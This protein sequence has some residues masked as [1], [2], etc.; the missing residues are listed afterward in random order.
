MNFDTYGA[1]DNRNRA[2]GLLSVVLL[3]I[4]LVWGLM[5]GLARKAVE[6]L[7]DPIETKIIEEVHAPPEMAPPP[8]PEFEPPPLALITPPEIVIDQPPPPVTRAL[9]QVA[10]M[11]PPTP[12]APQVK[13]PSPQPV[14]VPAKVEKDSCPRPPYPEAAKRMGLE[15][16]SVIKVLV[17]ADGKI[18]ETTVATSSGS[19]HLDRA[20]TVA[21]KRCKFLVEIIDGVPRETLFLVPFRWTILDP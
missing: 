15:G 2:I 9:T 16:T 17:G 12:P 10:P 4:L 8:K 18:K 11:P 7:P 21:S 5:N 20:A 13:V 14:R 19:D 1:T 3:H 6:L